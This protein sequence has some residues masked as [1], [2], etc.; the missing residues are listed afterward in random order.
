MKMTNPLA[1][2]DEHDKEI[3]LMILTML[4][5]KTVGNICDI[6]D[7]VCYYVNYLCDIDC[8]DRVFNVEQI[9]QKLFEE[10]KND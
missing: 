10:L 2:L 6:L 7:V 3:V 8:D 5:G 1:I 9:K 4:D